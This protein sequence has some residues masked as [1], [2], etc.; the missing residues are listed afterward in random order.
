MPV[1]KPKKTKDEKDALNRLGLVN[2]SIPSALLELTDDVLEAL[3]LELISYRV[4]QNNDK[5]V[6]LKLDWIL[7]KLPYISRSGLGKK[8]KKLENDKRIKAERGEGRHYHKVWYS[9]TP[10]TR[11]V[12]RNGGTKV[13]YNLAMAKENLEAS[14]VYA[15]I[16]SLLKV[17][18]H[19]LHKVRGMKQK[20][21]AFVSKVGNDKLLLDY[22][23]L[24]EG[25]GLNIRKIRKAARWLIDNDKLVAKTTFGNK[26][27]VS[28]P[29]AVMVKP[30]ELQ[31]YFNHDN[32]PTECYPHGMPEDDL[33]STMSI[34]PN[35]VPQSHRPQTE[36]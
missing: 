34:S 11:E 30:W 12:I 13:Y 5:A 36:N 6:W 18:D 16:I 29:A 26:K 7:E 17:Q 19:A 27:L 15:T 8:L 4:R 1:V 22:E 2:V 35:R 10:E 14:V 28:L 33:R 21:G 24:V 32:L 9:L 25:T 3:I 23:K 20:V 31:G